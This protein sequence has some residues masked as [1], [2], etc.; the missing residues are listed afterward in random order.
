V[1]IIAALIG[2]N[3]MKAVGWNPNEIQGDSVSDG[4]F[5]RLIDP[6]TGAGVFN[7]N[8]DPAVV[9]IDPLTGALAPTGTDMSFGSAVR[10]QMHTNVINGDF[11]VLPPGGV[12]SLIDSDPAS[13]TYN[14]LPGWTWTPGAPGLQTASIEA[15]TAYASGYKLRVTGTDSSTPGVLSQLVAV[16]MS[17]GQQY[18]VLLSLF[19]T[20]TG[21]AG[22]FS[23]VTQFYRADAVTAIGSSVTTTVG[24]GAATETKTDLGLVPKTAA[25]VRIAVTFNM[26]T[27]ADT[28]IGEVR[29]AFLP[30][31]ATV[32]LAS[33]TTQTA[34]ITTTQTAIKSALIPANTLVVGSVYRVKMIATVTSTVANVVTVRCRVGPTT[35]T[36]AIV[37]ST[38]PAATTTASNHPFEVEVE[39]TVRSVGAAGTVI[40]H[41]RRIGGITQPFSAT[42][43]SM[44]GGTGTTTIDTTVANLIEMTAVTAAGT[45]SIRGQQC[46]IECV[47]AS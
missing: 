7:P 44:E 43:Y 19:T 32:G 23:V 36:G 30:A 47:M 27:N 9:G 18:R 14:P 35:L 4:G 45:T 1:A 2:G 6:T 20:A 38:A 22:G 17:Q 11:A 3:T 12:G 37:A 25:Y 24:A 39:M 33:L 15:D 16:P 8:L 40:A 41:M 5:G 31:E 13:A 26:T 29:C 46:T 21:G 42:P 34:A 10:R 28:T